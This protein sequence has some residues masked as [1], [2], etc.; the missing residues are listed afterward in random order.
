V[1]IGV[2]EDVPAFVWVREGISG[3]VFDDDA[4]IEEKIT[5][6]TV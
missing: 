4:G 3:V 1:G 6:Y 5:R 2:D